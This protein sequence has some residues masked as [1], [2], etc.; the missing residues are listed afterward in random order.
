LKYGRTV[1]SLATA[2]S[3]F[4]TKMYFISPP[5]LRMP[6]QQL[7]DLAEKNISFVEEEDLYKVSN[8]LDVLYCTRIQKER[9]PDLMDY[10]RVKSRYIL[11]KKILDSSKKD[12]RILHPLPRVNELNYDLDAT[13]N[14]VYFEQARNG[15][16]IRMALLALVLGKI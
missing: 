14:A 4:K 6:K 2:L 7:D 15:V 3:H 5:E 11:D 10:E 1:H 13:E 9:F 12:L 8:K 16:P